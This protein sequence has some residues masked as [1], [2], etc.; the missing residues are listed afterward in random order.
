[1]VPLRLQMGKSQVSVT[2]S[3]DKV[4]TMSSDRFIRRLNDTRCPRLVYLISTKL[5]LLINQG[6]F[7]Q[8]LRVY[9]LVYTLHSTVIFKNFVSRPVVWPAL[10]PTECL[11][12]E[13]HE[14]FPTV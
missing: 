5:T 11:L 4:L 6:Y 14:I 13:F 9:F 3:I 2:Q 8:S 7:P 12:S 1:M 10:F